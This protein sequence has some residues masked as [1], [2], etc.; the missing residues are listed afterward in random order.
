MVERQLPKLNVAGSNPVSRS[1]SEWTAFHSKSPAEWLGI[2]H[3]APSFLLSAKSHARLACS[4]AVACK[5]T[6]P[7]TTARCRYQLFAGLRLAA[8]EIHFVLPLQ[9]EEY[10][11][12]QRAMLFFIPSARELESFRFRMPTGGP[13]KGRGLLHNVRTYTETEKK[14]GFASERREMRATI[15][16]PQ[17]GFQGRVAKSCIL[18]RTLFPFL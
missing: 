12:R 1:T 3:T 10:R 4:V 8:L 6:S 14:R 9:Q 17:A 18:Q 13:T 2:S 7:I 15:H 16:G 5:A 11:A